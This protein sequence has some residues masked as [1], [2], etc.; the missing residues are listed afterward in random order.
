M[1]AFSS[2]RR[3]ALVITALLGSA[4]PVAADESLPMKGWAKESITD[5]QPNEDGVLLTAEGAGEATYLGYFTRRAVALLRPDFTLKGR[6]TFTAANGDKLCAD[7][8]GGFT[9]ATKIE[10][11]Y[12]FTGGTG[13][14]ADA[15]GSADFTAIFDGGSAELTFKGTIS[16]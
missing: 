5:S 10:G 16:Y 14:F 6:V 9:T 15:S 4:L 7:L 13:R 11:T 3:F 12:T 1:N 8:D 2:L